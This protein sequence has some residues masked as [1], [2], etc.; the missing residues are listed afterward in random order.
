[1]ASDGEVAGAS[2][3]SEGNYEFK[4]IDLGGISGADHNTVDKK[5]I[6]SQKSDG[7][8]DSALA[9]ESMSDDGGGGVTGG[10][11]DDGVDI[12]HDSPHEDGTGK[13]KILSR[14]RNEWAQDVSKR[15]RN[16]GEEYISVKSKKVMPARELGPPCRDGCFGKIGYE[17][18]Q[19]I[20]EN[21]WKL[22]DYNSQNDYLQA[23]IQDAP[24]KRKKHAAASTRKNHIYTIQHGKTFIVCREAFKSIHGIKER[25]LLVVLEKRHAS[26][27]GTTP[28]DRR[29][30]KP[31]VR[32]IKGA[33]LNHVHEHIQSLPATSIRCD[34]CGS[35]QKKHLE[36]GGSIK[37]IHGQY[38]TWMDENYRDEPKVSERFYRTVF[39]RD[40]DMAFEAP[41]QFI[42]D[43]CNELS[44]NDANAQ[45]EA[46]EEDESLGQE[47]IREGK[48][49]QT[50]LRS[51]KDAPPDDGLKTAAIDQAYAD[52]LALGNG[53]ENSSTSAAHYERLQ[54]RERQDKRPPTVGTMKAMEPPAAPM[55]SVPEGVLKEFI[56]NSPSPPTAALVSNETSVD[57]PKVASQTR[58]PSPDLPNARN[59]SALPTDTP[60]H[61]VNGVQKE[62]EST[63]DDVE[64]CN[65]NS[66]GSDTT[67]SQKDSELTTL[68]T[69]SEKRLNGTVTPS[70]KRPSEECSYQDLK[71]VRVF[72]EEKNKSIES[73]VQEFNKHLDQES[74]KLDEDEIMCLSSVP[75]TEEKKVNLVTEPVSNFD[76]LLPKFEAKSESIKKNDLE[77]LTPKVDD[78]LWQDKSKVVGRL[79]KLSRK[80][81]EKII[82]R[83]FCE[84]TLYQCELGRQKILCEKL[85]TTL[86]AS[87]KKTAQF[88]KEVEDLKKVTNRLSA[89][90]AARKGQ[91]VAPIRIKRS[92]GIQAAP[93]IINKGLQHAQSNSIK[94]ISPRA[95]SGKGSPGTGV[96]GRIPSNQTSATFQS[97]ITPNHSPNKAASGVVGGM[98][99]SASQPGG[100]PQTVGGA[101]LSHTSIP[102]GPVSQQA[103]PIGA[104]RPAGQMLMMT[105]PSPG[106]MQTIPRP[107]VA[108]QQGILTGQPTLPAPGTLVK[109]PVTGSTQ[110]VAI[111]QTAGVVL[112]PN[113]STGTAL[114]VSQVSGVQSVNSVGNPVVAQARIGS[115]STPRVTGTSFRPVSA[116]TTTGSSGG[117]QSNRHPAPLPRTL[118]QQVAGL[119][120]KLPPQ[121]TLKL[122]HKE[123]SIVLSW[124][125]LRN[126]DHETIASYQ[127]YAYQEGNS[128]PNPSLWKKV[129]SVKALELPMA[130]TLTQFMPG[131][132]YHFA[133]RAVDIRSRL[134]P[135]SEPRSIRLEKK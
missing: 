104:V 105:Q 131:H 92:V 15:K 90:Q 93:H 33:R 74:K 132:V 22:G 13:K 87:R 6:V 12:A 51:S 121:P 76:S 37:G 50:L 29:G 97:K 47:H 45:G 20:F 41:R 79:R 39:T 38:C 127:L 95:V 129:G 75:K 96:Q 119:T 134:G 123:N 16:S 55:I 44:T 58:T 7:G 27:T 30:K 78:A 60:N 70:L 21:F 135:F 42:C 91:F 72:S 17:N 110:L 1:M 114:V 83:L 81:L 24:V 98:I 62:S 61:V 5:E 64:N 3:D 2:G 46:T 107:A 34:R 18:V 63:N 126:E 133:V 122:S 125:M 106:M 100:R 86:E 82:L 71:K 103:G 23:L 94:T 36:A 4:H 118:A 54:R 120:K 116:T 130:C 124:T 69:D 59:D 49:S 112:L 117:S 84:K 8:D 48:T 111:P 28:G 65:V 10:E 109:V 113:A 66:D 68:N 52:E 88:H 40:Y 32:A 19:T 67:L 89:E 53:T 73:S 99:L 31:N 108:G 85:E 101:T 14:E 57:S 77:V 128:P 25:K 115:L 35:S 80:E 26:D 43:I 11:Q 56:S 9:D 102:M